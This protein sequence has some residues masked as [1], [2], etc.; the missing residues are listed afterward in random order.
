MTSIKGIG[1]QTA[2]NFLV[3]M[4]GDINNFECSGNHLPCGGLDPLFT[5]PANMKAGG[6]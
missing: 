3:E 6:G 4:G 1:D 5:N 2:A